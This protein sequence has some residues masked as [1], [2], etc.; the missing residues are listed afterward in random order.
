MGF[1]ASEITRPP[2]G[3]PGCPSKA[4]HEIRGPGGHYSDRC[5][6]HVAAKIRSLEVAHG[7]P[8][9]ARWKWASS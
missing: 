1:Y 9:D 6:K 3:E 8:A 5:R 7:V 4:T 2:C